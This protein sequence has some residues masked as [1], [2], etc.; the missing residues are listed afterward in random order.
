MPLCCPELG[1]AYQLC[2]SKEY[3]FFWMASTDLE[4]NSS[5]SIGRFQ[6]WSLVDIKL[7][8]IKWF[9][10]IE[11]SFGV[12][13]NPTSQ[14]IQGST[15][16]LMEAPF[17]TRYQAPFAIRGLV[18]S[19]AFQ[20]GEAFLEG[21][22]WSQFSLTLYLL[23]SKFIHKLSLF[24]AIIQASLAKRALLKYLLFLNPIPPIPLGRHSFSQ[25]NQA[26]YLPFGFFGF[27]QIF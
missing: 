10:W 4:L 23:L 2:L 7:D 9:R 6:Q 22:L 8:T 17:P 13:L 1:L 19:I 16:T 5:F 24:E 26:K 12:G 15:H 14:G 20:I 11:S 27:H 18:F 25:A 3:V 21:S